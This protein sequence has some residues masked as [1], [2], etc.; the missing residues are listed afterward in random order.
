MRARP[1]S[2]ALTL[3]AVHDAILHV[4]QLRFGNIRGGRSGSLRVRELWRDDRCAA[5]IVLVQ[6]SGAALVFAQNH[7]KHILT[8]QFVLHGSA[9][10][11]TSADMAS[12]SGVPMYT[13][14]SAQQAVIAAVANVPD[15]DYEGTSAAA[16][17]FALDGFGVL[18][19]DCRLT[20]EASLSDGCALHSLHAPITATNAQARRLT[21]TP[22]V[23]CCEER[24]DSAL[25]AA[26]AASLLDGAQHAAN[27]AREQGDSLS[28]WHSDDADL[29]AAIVESLSAGRKSEDKAVV[30]ID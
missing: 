28:T 5:R 8:C 22:D 15:Q 12:S 1:G 2:R 9:V 23:A 4:A 20:G 10:G 14:Q 13:V 16:E 24:E 27:H 11:A 3:R 18:L 6:S 19:T 7:T 21:P 25:Q 29:N 17:G 26:L 30:I